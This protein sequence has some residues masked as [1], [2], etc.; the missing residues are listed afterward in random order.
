MPDGQGGNSILKAL[1]DVG[2]GYIWFALL[3]LWGG[4]VS[5]ISRVRRDNAP[6]SFVELVGE[7]TIS[8]FAGIMT[9][10]ICQELEFSLILTAALAGISGHMGGRAIYMLEQFVCKKMGLPMTNRR[11]DDEPKGRDK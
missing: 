6:F 7:W 5:Y 2:F 4:T 3:A 8:A 9:A 10:L 11:Y 1:F